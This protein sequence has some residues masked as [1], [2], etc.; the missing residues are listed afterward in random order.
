MSNPCRTEVRNAALAEAEEWQP[1]ESAP[2][3]MTVLSCRFDD[4]VG[5]WVYAAVL[6]PPSHPFTHWRPLPAPPAA[7][8]TQPANEE[9]R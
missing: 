4:A 8:K 2:H 1:I 9:K 5:E 7:L 6:S 3:A